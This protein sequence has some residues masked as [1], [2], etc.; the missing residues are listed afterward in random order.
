MKEA[1]S[2]HKELSFVDSG[3]WEPMIDSVCPTKCPTTNMVFWEPE[4]RGNS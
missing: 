3:A 1:D 2:A 4:E